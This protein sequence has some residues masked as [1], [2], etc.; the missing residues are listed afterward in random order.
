MPVDLPQFTYHP[1][2]LDTGSAVASEG[3]CQVCG[4]LR[5]FVYKGPIYCESEPEA[6]CPWCIAD[7][8]AHMKLKAEFVDRD[9]IGGDKW[10][11]VRAEIADAIAYRTPGFSGWQQ[12]RWFTHCSDGA[13]FLGAMGKQELLR[14]GA[15]AVQAIRDESGYASDEWEQYFDTLNAEHGP[16]TAYLFQCRHCGTLGGYSDCR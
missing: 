1:N 14:A 15:D 5:K 10:E 12:E 9:S 2:P 16:A 8:S 6:V 13:E 7:G 3:V 4:Q 11:P